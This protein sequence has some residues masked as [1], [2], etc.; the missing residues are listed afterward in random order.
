M[1]PTIIQDFYPEETA[2]CYGCGRSN[3]HELHVRT[4]WDGKE[5]VFRFRPE[6][7]HTGYPGAVY[8]GLIASIMDCHCIGTAVGALYQAE[9]RP[10]GTEPVI[11]CVTANLNVSYLRPTPVDA[12]LFFK[13]HVKTLHDRKVVVSCSV[14]ANG[15]ECARGE[16]VAVRVKYADEMPGEIT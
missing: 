10:P 14:T 11:R 4:A 1:K 16:I 9:A 6:P 7:H 12:E 15:Q 8:G 2:V 3:P 13:S 5:G